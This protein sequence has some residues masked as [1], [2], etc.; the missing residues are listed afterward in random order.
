VPEEQSELA[1]YDQLL[2]ACREELDHL[3]NDLNSARQFAINGV[4]SIA[5]EGTEAR[6]KAL[7][8]LVGPTPWECVQ[9]PLLELGIYQRIHAELGVEAPVDMEHVARTRASID[10]RHSAAMQSAG[11]R[12]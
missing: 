4:W 2:T 3:W 6:I 12:S 9:I 5:C 7:T 1:A 11:K 10:A 8:P